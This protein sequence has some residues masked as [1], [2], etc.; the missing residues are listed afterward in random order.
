MPSS[1]GALSSRRRAGRPSITPG[2]KARLRPGVLSSRGSSMPGSISPPCSG[3]G[4]GSW[5][6]SRASTAAGETP[7]GERRGL[8]SSAARPR[9]LP[10]VRGGCES[11]RRGRAVA[12]SLCMASDSGETTRRRVVAVSGCRVETG[13]GTRAGTLRIGDAGWAALV[14]PPAWG[15]GDRNDSGRAIAGPGRSRRGAVVARPRDAEATARRSPPR[16]LEVSCG[17]MRDSTRREREEALPVL[18]LPPARRGERTAVRMRLT[19]SWAAR[20][21]CRRA[22]S[23]ASAVTLVSG[24][25]EGRPRR[26]LVVEEPAAGLRERRKATESSVTSG[27]C[28]RCGLAETRASEGVAL[29]AW[30]GARPLVRGCC[31]RGI[32]PATR[33]CPVVAPSAERERAVR[34]TCRLSPAKRG[35]EDER[36]P[37]ASSERAGLGPR[38]ATAAR[39]GTAGEL[40]AAGLGARGVAT[41]R[42]RAVAT[43]LWMPFRGLPLGV[44]A[45]VAWGLAGGRLA[46]RGLPVAGWAALALAGLLGTGFALAAGRL[47]L[48]VEGGAATRLVVGGRRPVVAALAALGG[49]CAPPRAFLDVFTSVRWRPPTFAPRAPPVEPRAAGRAPAAERLRAAGPC[50]LVPCFL[51]LCAKEATRELTWLPLEFV[52]CSAASSPHLFGNLLGTHDPGCFLELGALGL[53]SRLA[54]AEDAL[55]RS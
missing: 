39:L 49:I 37:S 17:G 3:F 2:G 33:G 51:V 35:E 52:E 45:F 47:G 23:V 29:A 36:C 14:L 9:R 41:G 4:D 34:S 38:V 18:A 22:A 55:L 50:F 32:W 48:S 31:G 16:A 27:L 10:G 11:D 8:S 6:L 42:F 20:A 1:G 54:V 53:G 19:A 30:R 28:C 43:A 7:A 21:I 26:V 12:P 25:I 24:R 40:R 15:V 44:A 5:L 13:A 46:V